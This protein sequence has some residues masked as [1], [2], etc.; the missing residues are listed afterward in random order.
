M[1]LVCVCCGVLVSARAEGE[2]SFSNLLVNPH[3]RS[4][5]LSG[6]TMTKANL[7]TWRVQ[8]PP[9]SPA[10]AASSGWCEKTQ[11]VDL[12]A[13][14]LTAAYL[15]ASPLVFAAEEFV[16]ASGPAGVLLRVELLDSAG[17]PLAAWDSRSTGQDYVVNERGQVLT[18]PHCMLAG[19]PSGVRFIRWTDGGEARSDHGSEDGLLLQNAGLVVGAENLLTNPSGRSGSLVGWESLS[20]GGDGWRVSESGGFQTSYGW[21]QKRQTID[22][23]DRGF[24][25]AYLDSSPPLVVTE[26]FFKIYGPDQ[27][28]LKVVLLDAALNVLDTFD[29]GRRTHQRSERKWRS[30][31]ERVTHVFE[32][33]PSGVRF[34]VWEDGGRDTEYWAGHYGATLQH[35]HLGFLPHPSRRRMVPLLPIVP[36]IIAIV[37]GS[38]RLPV[39]ATLPAREPV[40]ISGRLTWSTGE[41]LNGVAVRT[42]IGSLRWTEVTDAGGR[43]SLTV[44]PGKLTDPSKVTVEI[45]LRD[46]VVRVLHESEADGI[47]QALISKH[48]SVRE[49][50]QLVALTAADFSELPA[51]AVLRTA[52]DSVRRGYEFAKDEGRDTAN[53]LGRLTIRTPDDN[54]GLAYRINGDSLVLRRSYLADRLTPNLV[55]HEYG[56]RVMAKIYGAFDY[57]DVRCR[58]S[59]G[60]GAEIDEAC[61]WIEGWANF[62][63][64]AARDNPKFIYGSGATV[65]YATYGGLS[66]KDEAAVGAALW[67]VRKSGVGLAP[68]LTALK[69]MRGLGAELSL[70]GFYRV[71]R[72]G[73]R[74]S[75]F[76][77]A[78]ADQVM[79]D[80]G[81]FTRSE[82]S[83][84]PARRIDLKRD[85]T[86]EPGQGAGFLVD[87][88]IDVR[89]F[90]GFSREEASFAVWARIDTPAA[91]LDPSPL[92]PEY[93]T[94]IHF[95][96]EDG[97]G[98]RL[99]LVNADKLRLEAAGGVV[100]TNR[101]TGA[102]SDGDWHLVG[103][104]VRMSAGAAH[105]VV[106]VDGEVRAESTIEA[107]S[108]FPAHGLLTIGNAESNSH[109][110]VFGRMAFFRS[111][112]RVLAPNEF[113]TLH[114]TRG[115]AVPAGATSA[116]SLRSLPEGD[117]SSGQPLRASSGYVEFSDGE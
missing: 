46:E 84:E 112:D 36:W 52:W 117:T 116:W 45:R 17:R 78:A 63:S 55:I 77:R 60:P 40:A 5:D 26:D 86:V 2:S 8:A 99:K 91:S 80:R 22:L 92:P 15:D 28:Y 1:Y 114:E 49:G 11:I 82:L 100:K 109:E 51:E 42:A 57:E 10:I 107:S 56:H 70:R 106:Y 16:N 27:Y 69:E 30:E 83:N 105:L 21:A 67:S 74:L 37:K 61:A 62:F 9:A 34:I 76:V 48:M 44:D 81:V 35:A 68:M 64:I 88:W 111:W 113:R 25:T 108:P 72:K 71:L 75:E 73:D 3:G 41:E 14:G 65:D 104:S 24:D 79:I 32:G 110:S 89:A 31:S 95:R 53:E 66:R 98:A 7:G 33:Y 12:L 38:G 87:G 47:T 13:A 20:S 93:G 18:R 54:S 58:T 96:S 39:E 101:S 59:H 50:E 85:A 103:A 115:G 102:I 97:D 29:S 90:D 6:W 19:Y 94:L 4:G 23:L 43:F